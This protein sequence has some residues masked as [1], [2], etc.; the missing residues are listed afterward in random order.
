MSDKITVISFCW[1]QVLSPEECMYAV[2]QGAMAV[3]CRSD[4]D[5][6]L[7]LLNQIH[8]HNSTVTCIAERAFL[9]KLVSMSYLQHLDQ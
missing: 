7:K 8:D 5:V 6:T 4:D 3:E 2:S 9:R 1:L